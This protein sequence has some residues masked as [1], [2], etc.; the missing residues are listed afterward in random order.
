M[1]DL[2]YLYLELLKR[3][4][5][6]LAHPRPVEYRPAATGRRF[7]ML[8][9]PLLNLYKRMRKR[10]LFI[11]EKVVFDREA[12]MN[13]RD[14]P[15]H[16]ETMIGYKRLSNVQHCVEEVIR[17]GVEGDLIETGVWRGGTVIFMRALLKA[18]DSTDRLVWVADSFE[19]LPKPNAEKYSADKDD[20]LYTYDELRV[21]QEMVE[22]N[23]RNYGLLDEQVRFLKGWFR[24][25]LP[26]AP[27]KKLAVLRLDGDMYESTMDALTHLYPK[28]SP[29]GY[30]IIDDWGVIEGC[31]LAVEDYRR[32]H[33]ITDTIL[34]IDLDGVYW[35][36]QTGP[37]A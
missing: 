18:F 33:Q 5:I 2:R 32:Q 25:T 13:G 37:G 1:N 21:S 11:C 6:D 29:N 12:R 28:L 8:V 23:F 27:V 15:V 4:L 34:P 30:I 9:R 3:T 36:K 24:D 10:D 31:R 26:T 16:A 19:G 35:K 7:R 14:W 20:I 17:N 22:A